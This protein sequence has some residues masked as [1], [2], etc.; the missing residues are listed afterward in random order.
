MISFR[1]PG[2]SPALGGLLTH[3][4]IE[5]LGQSVGPEAADAHPSC[6]SSVACVDLPGVAC[7]TRVNLLSPRR[8]V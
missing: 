5:S 3:A 7:A 8:A 6:L 2:R 4:R 1:L